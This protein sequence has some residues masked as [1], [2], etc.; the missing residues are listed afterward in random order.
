MQRFDCTLVDAQAWLA[1]AGATTTPVPLPDTAALPYER[2]AA[3][4]EP[5]VARVPDATLLPGNWLLL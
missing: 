1:A 5:Y 4:Y 3:T 2:L